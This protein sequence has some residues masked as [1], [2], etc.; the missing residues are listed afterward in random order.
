VIT[1]LKFEIAPLVEEMLN[2]ADPAVFESSSSTFMDPAMAGGQFIFKIIERLRANGHSDEN[3]KARVFGF[4]DN[5]LYVDYVAQKYF[6]EHGVEIPATLEVGGLKELQE[7]NMQFDLVLGN[8]PY[9]SGTSAANV[10]WN[11]FIEKGL[12]FLKSDGQIAMVVTQSFATSHQYRGLRQNLIQRGLKTVRF[13]PRETFNIDQTTLYFVSASSETT[14]VI[15]SSSYST[16]VSDVIL[17]NRF[18]DSIVK[19]IEQVNG[20]GY[21]QKTAYMFR[22]ELRSKKPCK[23]VTLIN[24]TECVIGDG[25]VYGE[26]TEKHKV[27]AS[28]LAN[29]LIA[30][31]ANWYCPPGISSGSYRSMVVNTKMEGEV[32]ESLFKSKLFIAIFKG[33][34]SSRTLDGMQMRFLPKLDLTRTWTD[35][36]LYAHSNLTQEEINYIEEQVK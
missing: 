12:K 17:K 28:Y 20:S 1:R 2:Q 27:V 25:T 34:S 16:K 13:L 18:L 10:I 3:I 19:K 4:E 26:D 15:E 30:I 36:E 32:L 5:I 24:G 8:P 21:Y 14:S 6:M 33:T 7:A 29:D 11:K 9:T 31:R 35:Q 22:D 23:M